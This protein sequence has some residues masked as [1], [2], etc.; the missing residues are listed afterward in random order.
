MKVG[1]VGT[2]HVATVLATAWIPAGAFGGETLIDVATGSY[3]DS[4]HTMAGVWASRGRKYPVDEPSRRAPAVRST[5]A[6]AG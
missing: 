2:G 6:R 3:A 5:G 1:V 4:R